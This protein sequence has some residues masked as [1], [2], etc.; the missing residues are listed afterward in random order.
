MDK[1]MKVLAQVLIAIVMLSGCIA[2][3][4]DVTH[5]TQNPVETTAMVPSIQTP[6]PEPTPEIEVVGGNNPDIDYSKTPYENAE[7]LFAEYNWMGGDADPKRLKYATYSYPEDWNINPDMPLS[8]YKFVYNIEASNRYAGARD[9]FKTNKETIAEVEPEIIEAAIREATDYYNKTWSFDYKHTNE[10][11]K[12]IQE[13]CAPLPAIKEWM[14]NTI[15]EGKKEKRV[16]Y[17]TL[18][19]DPSLVYIDVDGGIRVR[20]IQ[21]FFIKN[22]TYS[23]EELGGRKSIWQYAEIEFVLRTT[24]DCANACGIKAWRKAPYTVFYQN[25]L[26]QNWRTATRKEI[27]LM[28]RT[29]GNPINENLS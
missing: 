25:D 15:K 7:A 12:A 14:K 17:A 16:L 20:G 6:I 3:K 5:I 8:L 24:Q 23:N 13:H 4:P 11:R 27:A 28:E 26:M 9:L 2:L 10:F 19:T 22:S 21:M 1:V 29:V 18:I